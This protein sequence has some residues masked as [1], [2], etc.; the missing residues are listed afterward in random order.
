MAHCY[1]DQNGIADAM[2]KMGSQLDIQISTSLFEVLPMCAQQ[3]LWAD[4]VGNIFA[5]SVKSTN[6]CNPNPGR[7]NGLSFV[8]NLD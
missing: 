1:R 6:F 2:E 5:R 7:G 3:T 4:M 8:L